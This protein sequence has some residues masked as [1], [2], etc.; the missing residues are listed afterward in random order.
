MGDTPFNIE[1]TTVGMVLYNPTNEDLEMQYAGISIGLP[2]GQKQ[3]FAIKCASHLLNAYGQRGLCSLMHGADEDRVG[4][5]GIQRNYE[6]KK[7]Q[8]VEYNQRNE[9]R[10]A[11]K[12]G[13]LPPT[14]QL[15]AYAIELG[16]GL[17]EPYTVR[18][19][20]R[21]VLST[22]QQENIALK[23]QLSDLM[24]KFNELMEQIKKH[25]KNPVQYKT[26]EKTGA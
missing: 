16:I 19:E 13:Y 4:R 1:M 9:A 25:D 5:A 17:L 11:M 26:I 2:A 22:L 24:G 23:G 6:F 10:K 12:L 15:K 7:R 3:A 14:E 21:G 20:E 18:D 8:I